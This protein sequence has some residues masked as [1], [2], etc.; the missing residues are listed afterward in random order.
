[1][2]KGVANFGESNRSNKFG[3]DF[4]K[5]TQKEGRREKLKA[6]CDSPLGFFNLDFDLNKESTVGV[7]LSLNKTQISLK[8]QNFQ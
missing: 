3:F 2:H 1:M 5:R 4:C 6:V 7:K 8:I